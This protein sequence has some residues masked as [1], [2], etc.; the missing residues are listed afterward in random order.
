MM[1]SDMACLVGQFDF[2]FHIHETTELKF[3]VS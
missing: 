1:Q 2:A 3:T